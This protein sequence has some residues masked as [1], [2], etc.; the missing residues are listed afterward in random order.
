MEENERITANAGVGVEAGETGV[1]ENKTGTGAETEGR[2]KSR[3][4][5]SAQ[6]HRR[7]RSSRSS[8]PRLNPPQQNT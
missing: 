1:V 7:I 6:A 2:Q 4:P 8:R 5:P 3:I